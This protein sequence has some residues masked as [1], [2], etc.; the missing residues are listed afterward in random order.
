MKLYKLS[1]KLSIGIFLISFLCVS[2]YGQTSENTFEAS[3]TQDVASNMAG[4][5]K[6]GQAQ[7]GLINL[8]MALHTNSI[9]LWKNGMLRVHIQ[10]TYGQLP[11]K[12]LIGDMQVFSNIENGTYTYLYQ[13]WYKQTIGNFSILAG[14]HDLNEIFFASE[15]AGAYV[16]SSF[17]IMPVASLNVPVS[18]F[19]MTT[20]GVVAN[21]D[22]ND[23][24]SIY[25]GAY[26]GEPGP[27]TQSNFGT[28]LNL[29]QN[30]GQFYV[31]E[32][33]INAKIAEKQ[34]TYKI[35][36]FHHSGEFTNLDNRANTQKGSGGIY[37]I[38]DQMLLGSMN[39][40]NGGLGMLLQGGYSPDKSSINDFYLAYG[41]NYH[42]LFTNTD[43]MGLAVAHAST[44]NILLDNNQTKYTMCETAIELTYKYQLA[45]QLIIQPDLQY[46]IHPGMKSNLDNAFAG[47]FRIQWT[48]N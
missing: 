7:L 36:A 4:G 20:L 35:G 16:N 21:Y 12:N 1:I 38:A 5:M 40:P 3:L 9:N 6:T 19:P 23:T 41:L 33:H 8:D 13:L 17:G 45:N 14:K 11:T 27:L 2:V 37:F 29:N 22:F 10:N 42:K 24:Y 26:N 25:A 18:I 28:N 30:N 46:I 47:I 48:I 34:G 44:N 32:F 43:K 31:G 39:S 15:F